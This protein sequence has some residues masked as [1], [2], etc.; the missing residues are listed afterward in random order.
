MEAGGTA[1]VTGASRGIGRA[2]ALDLARAGFDVVATMRDPAAGTGLA[3]EAAGAVGSLTVARL[4]VT[5]PSSFV[6]PDRLR[7]LVNNAGTELDY[8]PVE[9]TPLE[10]WRA[11]FETNLFGLVDVTRHAIPSLKAAGGGVICS[12]TSS[13]ILVPVPFY[14]VYRASKA[15]VEAMSDTLRLEV[16]PFGIRVVTILPGPVESDMLANADRPREAEAYPDY[17]PMAR[18]AY[19]LQSGH[20]QATPAAVAAGL[21][22]QAIL[23][24]DP[25]Q[26]WHC[27]PMGEALLAAWRRCPDDVIA[28][29]SGAGGRP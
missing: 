2:V 3:A 8:L 24:D 28:G 19:E 16:E 7:V 20:L 15:A 11:V 22:R 14:A 25:T 29:L 21:I 26:R 13:S 10:Q 18:A 1:L 23:S 5:D 12:I 17:A 4:D 6:I 9:H 27:D